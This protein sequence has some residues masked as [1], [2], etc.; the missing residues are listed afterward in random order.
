MKCPSSLS[1]LSLA[2]AFAL[3]ACGGGMTSP[4]PAPTDH[5]VDAGVLG[6]P[7]SNNLLVVEYES[8]LYMTDSMALSFMWPQVD[9]NW[10]AARCKSDPGS[11]FLGCDLE[12]PTGATSVVLSVEVK[13]GVSTVYSCGEKCGDKQY[14]ENGSLTVKRGGRALAST[15]ITNGTECGCNHQFS[16]R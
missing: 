10:Y 7:P 13:G 4:P 12:I 11:K 14:W 8:P 5:S 16:L 3:G 15:L 6:P 2:L 1:A 9:N